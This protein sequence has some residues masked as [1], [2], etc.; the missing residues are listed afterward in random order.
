M[1]PG[2]PRDWIPDKPG[3]IRLACDIHPHMRGYVVVSPTPW[4]KVCSREGRFRLKDVPEGRYVLRVWHEMGE[5]L[6]KEVTIGGESENLG[7]LTL[8]GPAVVVAG[9]RR[10]APVRAWPEVIDRISVTLAA[11]LKAATRSGEFKKARRLAEDAYWGEFEA[12]DM[13]RAVRS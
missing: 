2:E 9:A 12:S 3:V 8:K 11:S 5:P 6:Q 4:V 13:E 10:E 7:V 1:A